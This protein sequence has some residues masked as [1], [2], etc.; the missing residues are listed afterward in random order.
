[1]KRFIINIIEQGSISVIFFKANKFLIDT[2]RSEL[3]NLNDDE[4]KD[5]I[6]SLWIK[7]FN[8]VPKNFPDS[9]NKNWDYVEFLSEKD[10]MFFYMKWKN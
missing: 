6:K 2:Y 9:D 10:L 5:Y 3:K 8:A 1:M 4:K 7:I